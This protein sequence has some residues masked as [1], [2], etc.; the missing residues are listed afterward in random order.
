[1]TQCVAIR[2]NGERCRAHALPNRPQCF[3][4]DPENRERATAARRK[5]G[6]NSS[7]P[8][9]AAR[10]IPKDM[11]ELVSSLMAAIAEVHN[12][13]LDPKRLSA[14]ASGAGAIVRVHEAGELEQRLEE[15]EARAEQS[16]TGRRWTS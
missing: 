11:R 2:T 6:E 16:G 9:R 13:E 4:H 3:A 10:R 7:N 12:G 5:G 14:M 8:A 1:M 15:L